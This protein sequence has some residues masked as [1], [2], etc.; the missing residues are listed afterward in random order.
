VVREADRIS[1]D[2]AVADLAAAAA[3]EP[4]DR[5]LDHRAVALVRLD[6]LGGKGMASDALGTIDRIIND[7]ATTARRGIAA[8]TCHIASSSHHRAWLAPIVH[9][10]ACGGRGC[11][12][13]VV[14]GRGDVIV[15][16]CRCSMT[17]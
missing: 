14:Q 1:G 8:Q 7:Y 3:H 11:I 16:G 4:G 12:G 10:M 17:L 5:A 15:G 6:E 13:G 9:E 2:S